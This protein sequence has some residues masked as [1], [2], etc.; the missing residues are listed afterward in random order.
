[1]I[2]VVAFIVGTTSAILIGWSTAG[3]GQVL[4]RDPTFDPVEVGRRYVTVL[5]SL[6]GFAVTGMVLLV[7][8]GRSVPG[9]DNASFTAVVA[10]F[11]VAYVGFLGVSILFA[12]IHGTDTE[13]IDVPAAMFAGG[14]TM[15]WFTI[16]I[17]WFALVPLFDT[18]GLHQLADLAGWLLLTSTVVSYSLNAVHVY[19]TGLVSGRLSLLIP[20]MAI[21]VVLVYGIVLMV[22]QI[23][24]ADATLSLTITALLIGLPAYA[25]IAVLPALAR[26]PRFVPV[27]TTAAPLGVFMLAQGCTILV[28]LLLFT[29]LT[30]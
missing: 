30:T 10:M 23:K 21:L 17:G 2:A 12:N 6:A 1:M 9:A 25:G 15:V 3:R 8:F 13:P 28:G 18:V 22:F 11:L 20:L 5:G 29:L 26:Q 24:P 4:T 19:R 16:G 27:V 14:T 7:T